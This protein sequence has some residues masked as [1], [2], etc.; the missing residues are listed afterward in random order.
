MIIIAWLKNIIRIKIVIVFFIRGNGQN[1]SGKLSL[2]KLYFKPNVSRTDVSFI[3]DNKVGIFYDF[4]SQWVSGYDN[5]FV[6]SVGSSLNDK[7]CNV[8]IE[9]SNG[10]KGD[11]LK[12]DAGL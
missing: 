2:A 11:N 12:G 1:E 7:S 4:V 3:I 6:V 9:N 5:V 8:C 10:Y